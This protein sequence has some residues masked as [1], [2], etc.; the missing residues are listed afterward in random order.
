MKMKLKTLFSLP[1]IG[2]AALLLAACGEEAQQSAGEAADK[3][4]DATQQSAEEVKET[5]REAGAAMQ[6][7]YEAA[8][9]E[10]AEMAH[11]TGEAMQEGVE[12]VQQGT[13]RR[14][15]DSIP[16]RCNAAGRRAVRAMAAVAVFTQQVKRN[17]LLRPLR[18]RHL[19]ARR[20]GQLL[21]LG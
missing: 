8:K 9:E 4:G 6:E 18:L 5:A 10:T 21:L 15:S 2:I 19:H 1:A 7:G 14:N 20:S 12:R 16:T 17:I 11:A 13:T 3:A